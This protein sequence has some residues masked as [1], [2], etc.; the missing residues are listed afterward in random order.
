MGHHYAG[1][2][3]YNGPAHHTDDTYTPPANNATY[4]AQASP[5][6]FSIT[7][8]AT[9]SAIITVSDSMLAST[10]LP[11]TASRVFVASCTVGNFGFS[12]DFGGG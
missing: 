5:T 7:L 9:K 6:P 10:V 2:H 8:T 12:C 4:S 11:I 3:Q 1:N